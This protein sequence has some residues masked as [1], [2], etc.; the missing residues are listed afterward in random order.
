MA[1]KIGSY[2]TVLIYL[3]C[4]VITAEAQQKHRLLVQVQPKDSIIRIM[5]IKPAYRP[6][7][8]L[9][10]GRYHILVTRSGFGSYSKWIDISNSDI[11]LNISLQEKLKLLVDDGKYLESSWTRQIAI[12]SDDKFFWVYP[13]FP[14]G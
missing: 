9:S 10:P 6:N 1:A 14:T 11:T 12:T 8:L 7:M 3:F 13:E 4:M 5:N 2:L